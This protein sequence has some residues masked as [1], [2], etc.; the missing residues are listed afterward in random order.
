MPG[1]RGSALPPTETSASTDE[2]PLVEVAILTSTRYPGPIVRATDV[3]YAVPSTFVRMSTRTCVPDPLERM[4]LLTFADAL[5][6]PDVAAPP[7]TTMPPLEEDAMLTLPMTR[8]MNESKPENG[9]PPSKPALC[10]ATASGSESASAAHTLS[11]F[12]MNA[13][14]H[15]E[16]SIP[17]CHRSELTA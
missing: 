7:E 5:E 12:L 6:T 8:E 9:K 3:A 11:A 16:A 15:R 14:I 1:T 13:I 17:Q 2:E 10:A 4:T